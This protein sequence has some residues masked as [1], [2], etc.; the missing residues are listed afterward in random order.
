MEDSAFKLCPFCKEQIRREAIKCRFCGEWLE[1]STKPDSSSQ[2]TGA[3]PV[4]TPS[5]PPQEGNEPNSMKAVARTLDQMDNSVAY[6]GFCN[7]CIDASTPVSSGH[8]ITLNGIGG[9]F[10][11]ERDCCPTCG[12][13]V[14]SQWF[15]IFFIPV[16][17][18]GRYRVKYVA[19]NRYLS[20]ELP[21]T[22]K[23]NPRRR[24][25][26]CQYCGCLGFHREDC[27]AKVK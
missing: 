17:R 10:Y 13:V 4:L 3:T 11:G 19:P 8:N 1:P 16:F 24:R 23:R 9:M 25:F 15:C 12:S 7:A 18:V 20:R 27:P 14:Q 22:R 26:S 21:S 2:P 5:V 6:L